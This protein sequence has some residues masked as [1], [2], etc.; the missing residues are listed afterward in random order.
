MQD[1]PTLTPL[2]VVVLAL[3]DERPM[4]PYEM[5]QL[6]VQRAEDRIVKVNPGSLYHSV[7]RLVSH[8]LV[9]STGTTREGN[10]PERT[11]YAITERGE[12]ALSAAVTALLQ[13]PVAEYP[14]FPVGIAEAHHLPKETVLRLLEERATALRA[15]LEVLDAGLERVRVTGVER[16][17]WLDLDYQR[18]VRHTDVQW[19]ERLLD[20]LRGD[21]IP[22]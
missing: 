3:L 4:H 21:R 14:H 20:D 10:R 9:R 19:V 13:L 8:E 6:M 15:D 16:R 2:A 17:Y 5:Y 12:Q 1:C 18:A 11:T 22:W 7:D